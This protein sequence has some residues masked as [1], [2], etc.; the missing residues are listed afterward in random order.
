[1]RQLQL[2]GRA[3]FVVSEQQAGAQR[4]HAGNRAGDVDRA[5]ARQRD[6]RTAEEGGDRAA[7]DGDRGV[8]GQPRRAVGAVARGDG[9]ACHGAEDRGGEAVVEAHRHQLPGGFDHQIEEGRGGEHDQRGEQHAPLA[10]VVRQRAGRIADEDA[11]DRRR[12]HDPADLGGRCVERGCEW[13]QH[14]GLRQRGAED[15]QSADE[16]DE[17]EEGG[18]GGLHQVGVLAFLRM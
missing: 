6:Q 15:R 14:R 12:H 18:L 2:G 1:M 9:G 13:R 7:D 17:D 5:E 3:R 8:G 10:E 16:G 4:Q 11:G